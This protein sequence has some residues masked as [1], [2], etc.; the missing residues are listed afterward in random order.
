MFGGGKCI[1]RDENKD[2]VGVIPKTAARVYKVE[3][4]GSRG[5]T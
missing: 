5:K 2:L 1:I 4:K 3:H